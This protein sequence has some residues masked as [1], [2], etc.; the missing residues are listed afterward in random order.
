[1]ENDLTCPYLFLLFSLSCHLHMGP[2]CTVISYLQP[3]SVADGALTRGA[4]TRWSPRRRPTRART[5]P[6]LR[7]CTSA[8]RSAPLLLRHPHR[9]W[10]REPPAAGGVGTTGNQGVGERKARRLAATSG[11]E[12]EAEAARSDEVVAGGAVRGGRDEERGAVVDVYGLREG[13]TRRSRS[14]CG[15]GA[16]RRRR[17]RI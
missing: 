8:G 2:T 17:C 4:R 5:E 3:S 9:R 14:G 15:G 13:D 16:A 10:P 7:P 12:E 11:K 1:M 6:L